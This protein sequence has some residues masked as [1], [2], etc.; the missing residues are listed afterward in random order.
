MTVIQK[1]L[2]LRPPCGG[3]H[4][5]V[6]TSVDC[7]QDD[8]VLVEYAPVQFPKYGGYG[9]IRLGPYPVGLSADERTEYLLKVCGEKLLKRVCYP[10]PTPEL[11]SL[12]VDIIRDL[13]EDTLRREELQKLKDITG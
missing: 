5:D 12:C 6:Y 2:S 8:V 11:V 7:T 13:L 4:Y 9:E 10:S 1:V 3:T